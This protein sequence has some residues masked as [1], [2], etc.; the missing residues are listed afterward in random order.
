MTK[1]I[2]IVARIIE[3]RVADFET[4]RTENNIVE[5]QTEPKNEPI[6]EKNKSFQI[7]S[8]AFVHSRISESKG[9]V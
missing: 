5:V 3:S 2:A 8:Q 1:I 7:F 4:H 9:I 6:V